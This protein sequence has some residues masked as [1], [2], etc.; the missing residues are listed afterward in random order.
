[1]FPADEAR[2]AR[3]R[4]R[5][6][7]RKKKGK[8]KDCG[9]AENS[10]VNDWS[11]RADAN[12]VRYREFVDFYSF[13]FLLSTGLRGMKGSG[14]NFVPRI[15]VATF[16]SNVGSKILEF[17]ERPV[18]NVQLKDCSSWKYRGLII[19]LIHK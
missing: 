17:F 11:N 7:G 16:D 19:R 18:L 9:P 3:R 10:N 1:M 13:P 8:E 14:R 12:L 15:T 5:E 2:G 4:G 6:R